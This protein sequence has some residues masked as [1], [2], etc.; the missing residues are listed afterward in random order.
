MT[1]ELNLLD[2]YG[3]HKIVFVNQ[4]MHIKIYLVRLNKSTTKECQTNAEKTD[5]NHQFCCCFEVAQDL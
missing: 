3:Y 5:K 4:G 1:V 2:K